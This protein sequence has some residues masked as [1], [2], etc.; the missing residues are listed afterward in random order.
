MA[1][2]ESKPESKGVR[3]REEEIAPLKAL[4]MSQKTVEV[5]H[6]EMI[7]IGNPG[8]KITFQKWIPIEMAN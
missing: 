2:P 6:G 1:L 4:R 5:P 3:V 8:S 7:R